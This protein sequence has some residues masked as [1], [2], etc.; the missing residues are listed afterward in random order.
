[1]ADSINENHKIDW[2][3]NESLLTFNKADAYMHYFDVK[4]V[5]NSQDPSWQNQGVYFW[6]NSENFSKKSLPDEFLKLEHKT[7]LINKIPDYITLAVGKAIPWFGKEGGGEKH[8]FRYE[9]NPITI[10]E[11]HKLNIITYFDFVKLNKDNLS[12][13]NDRD[14]CFFLTDKLVEYKNQEFYLKGAKVALSDLYHK[15]LIQ[16]VK[17]K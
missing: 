4:A 7:F 13:L 10:E 11:A 8:F 6:K 9:G 5:K 12:I 16:I 3:I 17:V 1:M 14:S 2:H 15:G